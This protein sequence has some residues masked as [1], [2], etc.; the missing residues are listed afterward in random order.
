MPY[1][2]T[3]LKLLPLLEDTA[4][5]FQTALQNK[6]LDL[7]WAVPEDS[8]VY[9]D[10]N[11]L[12]TIVRNLLDNAIKFTPEGG[13]ITLAGTAEGQLLKLK[14]KDT[15]VGMPPEKLKEL[16]LLKKDRTQ[17]GTAGEKGS[18]LGLHLA[19]EL[20]KLNQSP[21]GVNSRV[22]KGTIF[23]LSLPLKAT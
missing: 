6:Q 21:L 17:P 13:R 22:G 23:T 12:S 10:A 8:V 5:P 19:H 7:E 3:Q 1:Q 9:S 2:P 11:A 18:G 15:G 4:A 14:V 20:S 16:F